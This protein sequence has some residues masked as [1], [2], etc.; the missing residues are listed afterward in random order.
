MD[1]SQ[2]KE[3][4]EPCVQP[5]ETADADFTG[6][7]FA[8]G[9]IEQPEVTLEKSKAEDL[10]ETCART[11]T[12]KGFE[13]RSATKEKSARTPN[14]RFH[15]NVTEFHAFLASSNNRAEIEE[16][17]KSL[18]T[19]AD[20]SELELTIW[21]KLVKFTPQEE[22]IADPI[23]TVQDTIE[24][25][26]RAA[27]HKIK[28]MEKDEIT[29]VR[30]AT[31]R[32]S[33]RMLSASGSS[34]RSSKET[35]INVKA[36][37]AALE[38]KIKFSDAIEEQQRVLNKLK[39][40]QELSETIGEEAVRKE[41]LQIEERPFQRDEIELPKE[42]PEQLIDRF[43][44]NTE[45]R[46]TQ[47]TAIDYLLPPVIDT[48]F[49]ETKKSAFPS[50][51][52]TTDLISG[53]QAVKREP[54]INIANSPQNIIPEHQ[55][56]LDL[57]IG[58]QTNFNPWRDDLAN[59]Y[60]YEDFPKASQP[61]S[62]F[63]NVGVP[64][65]RHA[66]TQPQTRTQTVTNSHPVVSKSLMGTSTHLKSLSFGAA[67]TNV[68]SH[69]PVYTVSSAKHT[70]PITFQ[71]QRDG[72]I[73]TPQSS[74]TTVYHDI[75]LSPYTGRL[76]QPGNQTHL[77]SDNVYQIT[78][79]LAK[80][81]QLQRLP[82]AKPDIFTGEETDTRFFIWET[83]FDALIDSAPV[84]AQQ[85]LYLLLQHLDGKA[86]KV[87]EQLQYMVGASPQIAY[88]EARKKLKQRFGRSGIVAT[89][90]EN[91]LANWPKITNN[92]AQGLRDLS[93]F[94]QQVEIAKTHLSSLQIFEYPSKIQTLVNKLPG[95]FL[96]KWS[97][98]VQT[99]QQEKGC[100]AFPTF[101]EFVAEVT[102]HADRMNIP[103]IYQT[104]PKVPGLTS[105]GR[106]TPPDHSFRKKPLSSMTMASKTGGE[107]KPSQIDSKQESSEPKPSVPESSTTN[108]LCLF[109]QT[110]THAE[111]V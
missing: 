57:G 98:K 90:F 60:D 38:Q 2:N 88:N 27:L 37:R 9:T 62:A 44:N 48:S 22:I 93:D 103:R 86:K 87:V 82:Q 66:S 61:P 34:N 108:K 53:D 109:H 3:K 30:S 4:T 26:R 67:N 55:S 23:S 110:R 51:Y 71:P 95:W 111:R 24:G 65:T 104:S 100:D 63:V 13:F 16:R 25:C 11:M 59:P 56:V 14:K 33:S 49:V 43:M 36:K 1:Q 76:S 50:L 28:P 32:K 47:Q 78:E 6:E 15:S 54:K 17:T 96:T 5:S 68:T 29:S 7:M 8:Q 94:L 42:T 80:V 69:Y 101:A 92:D 75:K 99:L 58:H 77:N 73:L 46:P 102:F 84:S 81:T 40:E 18:I 31:S 21:L 39:L 74:L 89:D 107:S 97:S 10:P 85:K 106:F 35:L 79:A 12:E 52:S 91:K 64:S 19:I 20:H 83:A 70:S 72:D 45:A 105:G 41:V